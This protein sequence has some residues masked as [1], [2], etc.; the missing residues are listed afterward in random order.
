MSLISGNILNNPI[1]AYKKLLTGLTYVIPLG[2][3]V[4]TAV[5]LAFKDRDNI[6]MRY[7][8]ITRDLSPEPKD[9]ETVRQAKHRV[10]ITAAKI[11][12]C[13][14]I[15][16]GVV[17]A[18]A[19][20][21]PAI[22]ALYIGI[23]TG[24]TAWKTFNDPKW[25]IKLIKSTEVAVVEFFKQKESESLRDYRIRLLKAFGA[26]LVVAAALS[27]SCYLYNIL[28]VN[29]FFL[30]SQAWSNFSPTYKTAPWLLTVYFVS[31]V[32]LFIQTI[33]TF[34]EKDWTNASFNL[35]N[36]L[37]GCASLYLLALPAAQNFKA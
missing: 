33:K 22:S 24:L 4:I 18:S 23:I 8:E 16:L 28:F 27:V 5:G 6:K 7:R 10:A 2:L 3:E 37:I 17:I 26:V 20:I 14:F 32:I 31:N 35:V 30:S 9:T 25:V 1:W 36:T 15:V 21:L 34:L 12:C 19:Q 11:T 13:S 29:Q